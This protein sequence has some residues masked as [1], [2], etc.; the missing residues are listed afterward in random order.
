MTLEDT[1]RLGIEFERRVQTM[2]PDTE[3]LEKLDTETIYSYLNQYQDKYVHEI[4]RN[5]DQ[6][7]SGSHLSAHVES[8]L[9]SL[10]DKTD[11]S[12]R[13]KAK[14]SVDKIRVSIGIGQPPT[15]NLVEIQVENRPEFNGGGDYSIDEVLRQLQLDRKQFKK[16]FGKSIY[17]MDEFS[18]A[19]P[20]HSVWFTFIP[21]V[22]EEPQY[23]INEDIVED[24]KFD[25]KPEYGFEI[26][27]TGR[28]ITYTLPNNF[29][30]YIRS[31]SQVSKS[32]SFK[33]DVSD[34]ENRDAQ[35]PIR[36]IPNKLVSQSDVW[37]L[38]E[39][40]H[41]SLRILRYPA[42]VLNKYADGNPTMTVIYDQYTDPTGVSITYYKQPARF[43][44]MTSTPCQLPLD[45]FEE[46]VSGAVDLY[47]QY[48][49][50]AVANK[51]RIQRARAEAAKEAE[52]NNA[53]RGRNSE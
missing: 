41:D 18:V 39:T 11:M 13:I 17:D 22:P 34:T 42:A 25:F 15:E 10:M 49:A 30:M 6:I 9:Q 35:L 27:D 8:V 47:V 21:I 44:L 43:S 5:L 40:P 19:I 51:E 48:V 20:A 50:G 1:R 28:C 33:A 46:L 36:V 26:I 12:I 23:Y 53:R 38:I 24:G 4:Y 45:A 16:L 52:R 3:F 37:R 14:Y 29:Y 7:Q 2:I 32:F 31:A